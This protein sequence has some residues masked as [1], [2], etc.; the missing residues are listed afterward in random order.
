[1]RREKGDSDIVLET[2]SE[3]GSYVKD[4]AFDDKVYKLNKGKTYYFDRYCHRTLIT[5]SL[6]L[7]SNFNS[8]YLCN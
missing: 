3:R 6:D 4:S 5:S 1:M 8:S 2:E 7:L